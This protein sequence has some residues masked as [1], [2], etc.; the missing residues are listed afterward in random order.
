[1]MVNAVCQKCE[2]MLYGVD[3]RETLS[4]RWSLLGDS[5]AV[6]VRGTL[7]DACQECKYGSDKDQ[8]SHT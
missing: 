2:K 4:W 5:E 1:M 3:E 6:S 7:D 8:G